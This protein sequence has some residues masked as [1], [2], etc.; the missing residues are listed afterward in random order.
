MDGYTYTT[1]TT[2]PRVR[3]HNADGDY[4]GWIEDGEFYDIF[5]EAEAAEM[6]RQALQR[7]QPKG[8]K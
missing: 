3:V 1:T 4:L 5:S 2:D 8:A 7:K 6:L